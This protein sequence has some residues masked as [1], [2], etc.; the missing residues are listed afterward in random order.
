MSTA[1]F[2]K[3]AEIRID[4]HPYVLRRL[5]APSE[6]QLESNATGELRQM[7]QS[8]M[9]EGFVSGTMTFIVADDCK[10]GNAAGFR[11]EN[12]TRQFEQLPEALRETAKIRRAVVH[13]ILAEFGNAWQV[14]QVAEK[15]KEIWLD[16][17][18]PLP[19]P[20]PTTVWR[21]TR[22]YLNSGRDIRSLVSC[23]HRRGNFTSRYP[24]KVTEIVRDAVDKIYL[25]EERGTLQDVLDYVMTEITRENRLRLASDQLPKPKI[26][27]IKKVVREIP[28]FDRYAARYGRQAAERRFRA[29]L[30]KNIVNTPLER[31]EI[32]HTR[33]DV[34]VLDDE[35]YL[36]LG[37]PWLTLCID[38]RTR[39]IIGFDLSF[40]PPSHTT[41]ARALKHA[42]M[43]KTR[44]S[45]IY[46]SVKNAWDAYGVMD[47]I[48]VDNGPEFH[49]ESLEAAC[50][51]LGIDIQYCPRKQPWYKGV[52]ERVLGTLNRGVAHGVPGTTFS[53]IMEKADYQAARK[54]SVTLSTLKEVVH[55]W[56][57]DYYHQ[58][59][60]KGLGDTPAH[61]WK[62]ETAGMEIRL[63][64]NP[65]DLDAVLGKIA[66]RRLTHK[67]IEI[68]NLF[69][70]SREAGEVIRRLGGE[71]DV[72]VRFADDELGHIYILVPDTN[73]YIT[74][75]AVDQAYAKGM[76]LWQH[77]I[78]RRYA[79][80][81]LAG[82]TDTLA[83]AEAKRRIRD[84]VEEDFYRK[85]RKTRIAN[86]RFMQGKAHSVYTEST[87]PAQ[88]PAPSPLP[89]APRN[90][91]VTDSQNPPI[92]SHIGQASRN[93]PRPR[94]APQQVHRL[95]AADNS[96]RSEV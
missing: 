7:S 30:G 32:D 9:L 66:T 21:W 54:A 46:Q 6:W 3:G 73:Q 36:P 4:G 58:R 79:V 87:V 93:K 14:K 5:I 57:V 19:A 20:H 55:V 91:P 53:N 92:S 77:K 69:Y 71:H 2:V 82:R 50:Y 28:E 10:P 38:V 68:N 89:Q 95:P 35:T 80:K 33:L 23:N 42:M 67:G 24:K 62:V 96:T 47:V 18:R 61:A 70:N 83:L 65:R 49:S 63:P 11:A 56:I 85:K 60:H 78:C 15:V 27:L 72:T 86:H 75:P 52:V 16:L 29:S 81:E 26:S 12:A 1:G 94:F 90:Q 44:L 76:S 45:A 48:V 37:R 31:V 34:F 88:L 84:L 17:K 39:M 59:P 41:V 22:R 64:A 51:S 40:D 43:P 25:T 8:A 13:Q 74:I